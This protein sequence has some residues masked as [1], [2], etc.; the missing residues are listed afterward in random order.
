MRKQCRI[1]W[2][3]HLSSTEPS[4]SYTFLFGWFV[5]CT[6]ASLD[7]VVALARDDS[8]LSGCQSSLKEIL[9]DTNGSM[10]VT[11]QGK[12]MFSLVGQCAV[13]PSDND[14]LFR[15]G[16]GDSD[17]RKYYTCGTA[18]ELNREEIFTVFLNR[19]TYI[20][21]GDRCCIAMSMYVI[22]YETPRYGAHHFSLSFWNS[23]ETVKIFLKKHKWIDELHQKQ[24]LSELDA[25]ILAMN[26]ATASKMVFERHALCLGVVIIGCVY[27]FVVHDILYF[28]SVYSYLSEFWITIVD[29]HYIK[30]LFDT[31][32]INIQICCGQILFWPILLQVN[33][34]SRVE[35]AEKA[36]LHKHSMWSSLA[37]DVL[38]LKG[39]HAGFK[40][41]TE[42]AGVL[43]MISLHA[44]QIWSALWFFMDA[45]LLYL[46][47]GLAMLGILFGM[48]V[49]AAFIRDMIV[50]V[51][52]HVSTLHWVMSLLYSQQITSISSFMV[53]VQLLN[54][55]G[56]GRKWNP[57]RQ[58]LDSYEYTLKQ[59]IVGSLIFTP[60]LLLLPTSV[61]YIFFTMM[62]SSISLVCML[63]EVVISI[64]HATPY[65]NIELR[66]V[67]RRRFPPGIWFE[68]VSCHGSSD[69]PPE[70][71]SLDTISS[72]SKNSLHLENISGRSHVLVAILHS[73]FLTVGEG[74][75]QISD[76]FQIHTAVTS[77]SVDYSWA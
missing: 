43:G 28:P 61:F 16:V 11:L 27:G 62:N 46:V 15:S 37:V 14:Q 1:W 9:C 64:M 54:H 74:L 10:A 12:S 29:M 42:L 52:L 22:L 7:I 24:P 19:I 55:F 59:H 57:L 5:S 2:L 49:P 26:S 76:F 20:G 66:L 18:C 23:S 38:L 3:K 63:I 67:R 71:V 60:L 73:N 6:P 32:W 40:L 75:V 51:T 39:V 13:Y 36:A 68:I 30:S 58:R 45:L 21:M 69:N 25:V 41:N 8:S 72:P 35:Y 31:A 70:I 50:L 33:D 17:Q 44:I 65:I 34:L 48:T 56:R 47:K 77:E 53:L 4:S